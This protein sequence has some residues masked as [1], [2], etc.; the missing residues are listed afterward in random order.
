MRPGES[1]LTPARGV[2]LAATAEANTV[3][4]TWNRRAAD[5]L[6][7]ESGVLSLKEGEEWTDIRLDPTELSVGL[8]RHSAAVG[9][10]PS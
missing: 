3:R 1:S 7:A 5:V 9:A 6:Q 8:Y 4:V 2:G 10:G